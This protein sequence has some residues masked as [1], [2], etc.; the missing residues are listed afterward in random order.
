VA[1]LSGSKNAPSSGVVAVGIVIS[2]V[3]MVLSEFAGG[4]IVTA[5]ARGIA[6]Q[7][8]ARLRGLF[9]IGVRN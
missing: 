2:S 1:P 3:R 9:L 7:K 6:A 4:E 5:S 8:K